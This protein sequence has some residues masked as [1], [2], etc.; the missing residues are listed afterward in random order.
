MAGELVET[1]P[2]S[3]PGPASDWANLLGDLLIR[4]AD[5]V[6][7]P[8]HLGAEARPSY[9]AAEDVALLMLVCRKWNRRAPAAVSRLRVTNFAPN[10][11]YYRLFGDLAWLRWEFSRFQPF[12]EP[13]AD[14]RPFSAPRLESLGIHHPS[15]TDT[16]TYIV[17]SIAPFNRLVHLHIESAHWIEERGYESV[18]RL[19]SLELLGITGATNVTDVSAGHL[20][21]LSNLKILLL[22]ACGNGFTDEG[23]RTLA[24]GLSCLEALQL[25]SCD[26]CTEACVEYLAD[27]PRLH[28]FFWDMKATDDLLRRV[29]ALVSL[30]VLVIH[31][32]EN[33]FSEDAV[34]TLASIRS[35]ESLSISSRRRIDRA[36]IALSEKPN[37]TDLCVTFGYTVELPDSAVLDKYGGLDGTGSESDGRVLPK[38]KIERFRVLGFR[39]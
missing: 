22:E 39:V 21:R 29:T 33:D 14:A 31:S 9:S 25:T 28:T 18:S 34:A 32:Y 11:S 30:R 24:S 8:D 15:T 36:M 38:L 26:G 37:F 20:A 4:V 16:V 5:T 2:A 7:A 13:A 10:S 6:S 19:T 3:E 27:L 23:V 1:N 12:C 35:L 17:D